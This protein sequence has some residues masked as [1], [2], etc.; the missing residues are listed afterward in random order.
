MCPGLKAKTNSCDP[1][2]MNLG[3]LESPQRAESGRRK[4]TVVRPLDHVT[5]VF[6]GVKLLLLDDEHLKETQN[7]FKRTY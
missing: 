6:E 7:S 4:I 2:L 5:T 1:I 3:L